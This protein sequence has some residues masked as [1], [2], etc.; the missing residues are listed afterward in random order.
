M[1][2]DEEIAEVMSDESEGCAQRLVE[3]ALE[4]GGRDNITCMVRKTA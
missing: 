1:C 2:T 4:N 3:K